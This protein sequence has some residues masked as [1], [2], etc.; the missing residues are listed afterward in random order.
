MDSQ[1]CPLCGSEVS[2]IV[3]IDHNYLG[4]ECNCCGRFLIL[5]TDLPYFRRAEGDFHLIS[6]Y[7][8]NRMSEDGKLFVVKREHLDNPEASLGVSR[9]MVS[10]RMLATLKLVAQGTQEFGA[11]VAIDYP[12]AWPQ[13][14]C[15]GYRE[16]R[17]I[18]EH[19]IDSG[20]LINVS[21]KENVFEV[22]LSAE[23]WRMLEDD[24]RN[25][26]VLNKRIFVAMSFAKDL[27][28]IYENGIRPAIGA[29]GFEA[30][31]LDRVEHNEK[32]CDKILADIRSCGLVVADFTGQRGG[33]YFEAGFALGLGK[34]VIWTCRE[35]DIDNLH[36]DTRQYNHI[37]WNDP[38]DLSA[39]LTNRIRA[40][41]SR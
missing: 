24:N 40:I 13:V 6:G 7:L 26:P 11:W 17:N 27:E 22:K 35:D 41:V 10:E 9:K 39:R 25:N 19:L 5:D 20:H 33:V 36:F 16:F 23:G 4:V 34:T 32:I 30:I 18:L 29:A 31:R 21:G 37:V 3:R 38:A 8:R 28:E 2:R 1:N 15:T 14:W 12:T